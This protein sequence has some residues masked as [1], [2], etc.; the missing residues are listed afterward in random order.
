VVRPTLPAATKVTPI[1]QVLRQ[2][3]LDDTFPCPSSDLRAFT[4]EVQL[5]PYRSMLRTALGMD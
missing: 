2:G 3:L 4:Y 1:N 5:S